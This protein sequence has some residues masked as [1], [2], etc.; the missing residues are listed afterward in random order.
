MS[1][2]V[3]IRNRKTRVDADAKGQMIAPLLAFRNVPACGFVVFD[4]HTFRTK[5]ALV[6]YLAELHGVAEGSLWRWQRQFH[7]SG[8]EGLKVRGRSDRGE[9]RWFRNHPDVAI[10]VWALWAAGQSLSAIY[11]LLWH[12][13]LA[14]PHITTVRNFIQFLACKKVN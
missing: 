8:S 13:L 5:S 4:G 14:P 6:S 12:E 3:P 1:C 2:S 9:P 10:K 11:E 7:A